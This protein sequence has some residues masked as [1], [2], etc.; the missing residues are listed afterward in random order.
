MAT[1]LLNILKN[2]RFGQVLGFQAEKS[3]K[4]SGNFNLGGRRCGLQHR[5]S[6]FHTANAAGSERRRDAGARLCAPFQGGLSRAAEKCALCRDRC[7][8]C[9]D[10]DN[11]GNY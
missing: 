5:V 10:I 2:L 3:R 6:R 4:R 7:L 11:L 9:Q 8:L 1:Q